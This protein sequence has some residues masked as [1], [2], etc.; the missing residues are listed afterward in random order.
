MTDGNGTQARFED[1]YRTCADIKDTLVEM[2]KEAKDDRHDLRNRIDKIGLEYGTQ[3]AVHD[4]Q[5]T[6]VLAK[7]SGTKNWIAGL[8]SGGLVGAISV[9]WDRLSK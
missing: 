3:L 4:I 6:D 5:I 8:V 1:L 7:Q 2:R 9:L